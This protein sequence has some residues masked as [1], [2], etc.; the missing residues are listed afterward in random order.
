[1]LIVELLDAGQF[2]LDEGD[3]LILGGCLRG[4]AGD[5][6]VELDDPLAQL[7]LSTDAAIDADV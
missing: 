3:F 5:F 4:E 1:M 6:L 2:L 7:R